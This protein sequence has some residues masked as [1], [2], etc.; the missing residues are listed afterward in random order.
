KLIDFAVWRAFLGSRSDAA[1]RPAMQALGELGRVRFDWVLPYSSLP[2]HV[3]GPYPVYPMGS[4][5][6][7]VNLDKVPPDA[8]LGFRAEWEQPVQF[9]WAIVRV[10]AQGRAMSQL[11][12]PYLERGT[13]VEKTLL[14]FQGASAL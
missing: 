14:N 12:L 6:I 13:S 7:W 10:D 9:Q 8:Q 2:R 11:N 1:H 3:A 4:A 5:Y